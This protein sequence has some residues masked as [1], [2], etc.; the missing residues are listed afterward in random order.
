LSK[1]LFIIPRRGLFQTTICTQCA[2]VFRSLESDIALVTIRNANGYKELID[3]TTQKS[4]PFPKVCPEC[5]NTELVSLYSGAEDLVEKLENHLHIQVE[6]LFDTKLKAS[7]ESKEVYLPEYKA[8]NGEVSV[9]TR[10][11]DPEIDYSQFA[12]I[13]IIQAEN[14]TASADYLVLEEVYKQ[15]FTLIS[16]LNHTQ[17]L[18]VDTTQLDAPIIQSIIKAQEDFAGAYQEFLDTET[19]NR[20]QFGLPPDF[21]IVLLTSQ[22][23]KQEIALKKIKAIRASL[24]MYSYHIALKLNRKNPD[25]A[26]LRVILL[27]YAKQL[28]LQVRL[29]PKHIL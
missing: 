25:F 1:H 21:G 12:T 4:Y 13:S 3:Y 7:E 14:L 20:K 23:A 27:D 6:K 2:H 11:Y 19:T 5:G 8:Y 10:I 18:I 17:T 28:N 24:Q 22:E 26:K 15:V 9:S 29:N 16:C